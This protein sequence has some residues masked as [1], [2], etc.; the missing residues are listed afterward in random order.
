[1][2]LKAPAGPLKLEA[3]EGESLKSQKPPLKDGPKNHPRRLGITNMRV[4]NGQDL[5]G[6]LQPRTLRV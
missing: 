5:T 6:I 1:M 3:P 2:A 4:P